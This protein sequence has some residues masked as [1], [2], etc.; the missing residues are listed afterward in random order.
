M[1]HK[2][3]CALKIQRN[4]FKYKHLKRL[5]ITLKG[6]KRIQILW[7]CRFSYRKFQGIRKNTRKIQ[8]FFKKK[9]FK[10]NIV[11]FL[12]NIKLMKK[13]VTKI[14]SFYKMRAQK[15]KLAY[16]KKCIQTINRLVR[17]HNGRKIVD[18]KRFCK[19]ITVNYIFFLFC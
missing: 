11:K 2:D 1:V 18:Y 5:R 9:L 15:K 14:S 17:G 6:F 7:K 19:L 13:A 3:N 16:K 4:F 12:E 10:K 8:R